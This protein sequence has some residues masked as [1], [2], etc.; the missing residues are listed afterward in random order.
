MEAIGRVE[1]VAPIRDGGKAERRRPGCNP[2]QVV[3]RPT[4]EP[5]GLGLMQ[6]TD[7]DEKGKLDECEEARVRF[8]G[9]R[10][11]Q[12]VWKLNASGPGHWTRQ[13]HF[14]YGADTLWGCCADRPITGSRRGAPPWSRADQE[15]KF[16]GS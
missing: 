3:N 8:R 14:E 4:A 7:R 6:S 1:E 15:E 9:G 16:E 13:D 11:E 5:R 12:K 2:R 10:M